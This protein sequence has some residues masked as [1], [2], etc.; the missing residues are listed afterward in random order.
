MIGI[1]L[2]L[3]SS[4]FDSSVDSRIVW[5]QIKR[6]DLLKRL[7][8]E[9][10]VVN[11]QRLSFFDSLD[12]GSVEFRVK[13]GALKKMAFADALLQIISYVSVVIHDKRRALHASQPLRVVQSVLA[14]ESVD[15]ERFLSL[16]EQ[17]DSV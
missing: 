4:D 16:I 3:F 5:H 10:A 13:Q 9:V 8:H 14:Q 2:R 15:S 7:V 12:N 11:H 6:K 17:R 1:L